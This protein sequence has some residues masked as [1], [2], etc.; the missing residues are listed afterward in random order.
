MPK[1]PSL[2][3]DTPRA[4]AV[5]PEVAAEQSIE[6]HKESGRIDA[7][8]AAANSRPSRHAFSVAT[9]KN[10]PVFLQ[11]LRNNYEVSE[12]LSNVNSLLEVWEAEHLDEPLFQPDWEFLEEITKPSHFTDHLAAIL[13]QTSGASHN[14]RTIRGDMTF[15]EGEDEDDFVV[16]NSRAPSRGHSRGLRSPVPP[17]SP[18]RPSPLRLT[19]SSSQLMSPS[20]PTSRRAQNFGSSDEVAEAPAVPPEITV[21]DD[22]ETVAEAVQHPDG[23]AEWGTVPQ[24]FARLKE[25]QECM[26]EE[27]DDPDAARRFVDAPEMRPAAR[28]LEAVSACL[29]LHGQ[30]KRRLQAFRKRAGEL[31]LQYRQLHQR[32]AQ[33]LRELEERRRELAEFQLY[34]AQCGIWEPNAPSNSVPVPSTIKKYVVPFLSGGG[35]RASQSEATSASGSADV[36][37]TASVLQRR[38]PFLT[39][40]APRSEVTFVSVEVPQAQQLWNQYPAAMREALAKF[41]KCLRRCAQDNGGYEVS[42]SGDRM[43]VAFSRSVHALACCVEAQLALVRAEWPEELAAIPQA[44]AKPDDT[45]SVARGLRGKMAIHSGPARV[46]RDPS[47][48]RITYWGPG[49]AAANAICQMTTGGEIWTSGSSFRMLEKKLPA[50][51]LLATRVGPSVKLRG[52]PGAASMAPATESVQQSQFTLLWRI[53]SRHTPAKRVPLPMEVTPASS[54]WT[55]FLQGELRAALEDV[56]APEGEVAVVCCDFPHVAQ[57]WREDPLRDCMREAM[58]LTNQRLRAAM[59]LFGGYEAA[60]DGD[61]FLIAFPSA[62]EACR[63]CLHIQEKLLY[64]HWPDEMLNQ[65]NTGIVAEANGNI[66]F[67]GLRCRMAVHTG[68]VRTERDAGT[69]RTAYYGSMIDRARQISAFSRAG[70]IVVSEAV[71]RELKLSLSLLGEPTLRFVGLRVMPGFIHPEPLYQ[72]LPRKLAN[73]KFPEVPVDTVP[74]DQRNSIAGWWDAEGG[75]ACPWE[76]WKPPVP[77]PVTKALDAAAAEVLVS[78]GAPLD[79]SRRSLSFAD[80]PPSPSHSESPLPRL[81]SGPLAGGS[82]RPSR[83]LSNIAGLT[84]ITMTSIGVQT[85]APEPSPALKWETARMALSDFLALPDKVKTQHVNEGVQ[86]ANPDSGAGLL[87][88]ILSKL[89]VRATSDPAIL[90]ALNGA[91]DGAKTGRALCYYLP[92]LAPDPLLATATTGPRSRGSSLVGSSAT[93]PRGGSPVADAIDPFE[94][95]D[96]EDTAKRSPGKQALPA[97]RPM[98]PPMAT[99]DGSSDDEGPERLAEENKELRAEILRL[100]RCVR[101]F[102]SRLRRYFT[103]HME[104]QHTPLTSDEFVNHWVN[105]QRKQDEEQNGKLPPQ[106]QS[107]KAEWTLALLLALETA[108]DEEKH[109]SDPHRLTLSVCA[110]LGKH[111]SFM[112]TFVRTISA[113]FRGRPSISS[114]PPS[115]PSSTTVTPRRPSMHPPTDPPLRTVIA[116]PSPLSKNVS[117]INNTISPP[118][119]PGTTGSAATPPTPVPGVIPKPPSRVRAATWMVLGA[120]PP[121]AAVKAVLEAKPDS[122]QGTPNT[123]RRPSATLPVRFADSES[124]SRRSSAAGSEIAQG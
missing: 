10:L 28:A 56:P 66:L 49:V 88:G 93:T 87:L 2:V 115:L 41:N 14:S 106:R 83:R 123:A 31:Y 109:S 84:D 116:R 79:A 9:A 77:N 16:G 47:S 13:G 92:I 102:L 107:A 110:L 104:P 117:I 80:V 58:K 34:A 11:S 37:G 62:R 111:F 36:Q 113:K 73:R 103:S 48:L 7:I 15:G 95:S 86:A 99:S 8:V 6:Y 98:T 52:C 72:M 3:A 91:L 122:Q 63:W 89:S 51:G 118:H 100:H 78:T 108:A 54:S 68:I 124:V 18:H 50:M 61:E 30:S 29:V 55:E 96:D 12:G 94:A 39:Q 24:F 59:R 21:G 35:T 22:E 81:N 17:H 120:P 101:H 33:A 64:L 74:A 67:R 65:S 44:D 40:A 42:M 38:L 119:S 76:G 75:G 5:R 97:I 105:W 1:K 19:H 53:V 121:A 45:T 46:E 69:G 71:S 25:A 43:L 82:R 32:H 112:R 20:P 57:L 27:I 85:D 4:P 114:I 90:I 23:D 26:L 70:E 60:T